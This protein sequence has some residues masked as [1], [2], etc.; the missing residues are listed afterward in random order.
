MAECPDRYHNLGLFD[1]ITGCI[2]RTESIARSHT[3]LIKRLADTVQVLLRR[4]NKLEKQLK[5]KECK[6]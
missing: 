3:M 6:C 2:E 5:N 4:I 1:K